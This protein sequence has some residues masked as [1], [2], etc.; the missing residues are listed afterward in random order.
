MPGR[1]V[2]RLSRALHVITLAL[3][4]L[5]ALTAVSVGAFGPAPALAQSCGGLGAGGEF[6][7]L[8][9]TRIYDSR[10]E[11]A[12]GSPTGARPA[13]PGGATFT[14]KVLGARGVVP[15]DASQVLTVVANVTVTGATVG[16]YLTIHRPGA[17]VPDASNVNF[18]A[19][20][21]VPDLAFLPVDA[22]GNVAVTVVGYGQG[23]VNVLIDVYG[24]VSSSCAT[25]RGARLVSLSP[26]RIVDTRMSAT[27]LGG[28]EV[29]RIPFRGADGITPVVPDVVPNNRNVVGAVVNLT[30]V[31]QRPASTSTFLSVLA[32]DPGGWPSTST[33]NVVRNQVKANLAIVPVGADGAIRVFN[34]QGSADI[35]VD[36][37]GYLLAGASEG[38]RA[39]RIVPLDNP[40]RAVDTRPRPLGPGQAEQWSFEPFT[41]SVRL[42]GQP[43]GNVSALFGNL[44][45]ANLRRQYPTVPVESFLT[46]YPS[47]VGLPNASNVNLREYQDVANFALVRLGPAGKVSFF[48]AAGYVDY[49]FDVAAVVLAD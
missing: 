6:H 16:G 43:V 32:E 3:T 37:V 18:T 40:F 44:T 38:T 48:N 42:D 36:V 22:S 34:E 23:S 4:A 26:T 28:R 35:V 30:V 39:G 49:L 7:P 31:N 13:T 5:T 27:P 41:S 17:A 21:S 45:A 24:Y 46:V 8:P 20:S 25:T 14:T 47:N 33:T 15:S 19:G 12:I 9:A 2:R 1:P 29:R 10:P 11:A